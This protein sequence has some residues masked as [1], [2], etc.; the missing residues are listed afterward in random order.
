MGSWR[1][2][3]VVPPA[4][5]VVPVAWFVAGAQ[6]PGG[7]A[8]VKHGVHALHQAV[9]RR[10]RDRD[11]RWQQIGNEPCGNRYDDMRP[12]GILPM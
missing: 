6:R 7:G 11:G 12:T 2:V 4:S 8:V 9:A 3:R 1:H 10:T 5:V